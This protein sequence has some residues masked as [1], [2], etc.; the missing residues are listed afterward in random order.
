MDGAA[1]ATR[2]PSLRERARDDDPSL[3]ERAH[4]DDPSLS[5]RARD[6]DL[7]DRERE[8]DFASRERPRGAG[9]GWLRRRRA[10][11]DRAAR[12]R[13]RQREEFGGVSWL[14]ALVGWLAAAGLTAILTGILGAAGAVLAVTDVGRNVTTTKAETIG[15]AG[16]IALLVV[17]AIAYWFGGWAAGRMARFDGGRQGIAVW[18]WGILAAAVIAVLAAIGGSEYNVLDRL[19]LP[20][21]PIDSGTLTTGGL[22]VLLSSIGVTLFAAMLGGK[23]G[24]RFHRKVDRAG[25]ID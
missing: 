20:R 1:R 23:A 25:I 24:E 10:G 12:A 18:L 8:D 9:P 17:L 22:L 14:S 3:R 6:D 7:S 21:V 4:D 16:A 5:E 2:D 19:N 11:D 15:L 13:E